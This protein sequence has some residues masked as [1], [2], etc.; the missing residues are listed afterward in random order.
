[1]RS[2]IF[3]YIVSFLYVASAVWVPQYDPC[4]L[5]NVNCNIDDFKVEENETTCNTVIRDEYGWNTK[6]GCIPF[7]QE[8]LYAREI[9]ATKKVF[10]Y[11]QCDRMPD[12]TLDGENAPADGPIEAA[13]KKWKV[14]QYCIWNGW[15]I[16]A[17]FVILMA[18]AIPCGYCVFGIGRKS[19]CEEIEAEKRKAEEEL[20][21]IGIGLYKKRIKRF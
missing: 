15:H 18:I 3:V 8:C 4:Q 10:N 19:D 20:E 9:A 2:I 5:N 17:A 6:T 16:V 21:S 11:I 12:A 7:L 13:C 14:T 1:M